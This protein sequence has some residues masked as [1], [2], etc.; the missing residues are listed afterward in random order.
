MSS[1]PQKAPLEKYGHLPRKMVATNGIQEA[2]YGVANLAQ[3][4]VLIVEPSPMDIRNA[5]NAQALEA[6]NY[7][8]ERVS[9]ENRFKAQANGRDLEYQRLMRQYHAQRIAYLVVHGWDLPIRIRP[10]GRMLDGTHRLKAAKFKGM[11]VVECWIEAEGA[12]KD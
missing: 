6:Q 7:S 8:E 10:D 2:Y 5:I 4:D 3:T 12:I 1:D 11:P 9:V